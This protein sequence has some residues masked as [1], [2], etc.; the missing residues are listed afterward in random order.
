MPSLL[1]PFS[2][3]TLLLGQPLNVI[4]LLPSQALGVSLFLL[5]RPL[6][7]FPAGLDRV[8]RTATFEAPGQVSYA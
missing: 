4:V 8:L 6:S 3:F 2:R 1:D 7:K 5:R